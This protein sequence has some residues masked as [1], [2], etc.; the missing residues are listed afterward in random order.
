MAIKEDITWRTIVVYVA[1][2]IF[3]VL[4]LG[5]AFIVMTIEGE[6]WRKKAVANV[7]VIP[8]KIA[9]N[10]GDICAEDG[11]IL[12]TSV[13]YYELR[14]DPVAVKREVF[15]ENIDSLALCLSH[16]FKDGSKAYYKN[17]LTSARNRKPR[18]DRYLL[19]NDRKVNHSELKKI[20]EFP[21]FRLGKNKGGFQSV[22]YNKRI[23]PHVNLASRTI[24]YLNEDEDGTFEGRVGFE[25]AFENQLKGEYGQGMKRMMSGTWMIIADREPEDGQDVVTTL[26]VDYQDIVQTA[27][28]RQL[29]AYEASNGTAI[30]MEVKTGDIKAIANMIRASDGSYREDLNY[31]I[32]D[33]GEPGSVIKAA[34]MIALLEDGHVQPDDTI[35]LGPTGKYKFYDRYLSESDGKGLGKVTVKRI[36]EKSSNGIAKLVFEHY[37][38]K[39]EKFIDRLY[40]MGLDKKLDICLKGEGQPYIKH[41]QDKSW[42]AI[43]LPW[44]S[45]GYE[46]RITPLQ[47]LA[48]YNAIANDGQRMRPRFVKEIRRHG[49]VVKSFSTE[50]VGSKICSRKTLRELK[51]ML[52]GVVE[53]GT[54]KNIYTTKY[55]IAGKTGTARMADGAK[56]YGVRK[57]RASFVGY[58][59]AEE[60]LYSCIVVI[61][62]PSLSKGF[63]ANIVS[64]SA[65]RE[66]SDKV[67]SIAYLRYAKPE[68]EADKSLP[69]S[70]NGLKKDF[71][72]V[73]DELDMDLDGTRDV[74]ETDWVMTASDK[75]ENVMLMPR[76]ITFSTVPNVKGMGLR[77]ALFVL[78]NSGLKV[79]SFG[80]GMVQSQS[81]QPGAR[82]GRGTYI[83]IELR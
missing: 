30:L 11:R 71:L 62:N 54:A 25:G 15:R 47:V 44:M 69:V 12:A 38:G 77:D 13:P 46:L 27:L 10:R 42:N 66:I 32:G 81:I 76:K 39:P 53:E 4:V 72:T 78:E 67:Y 29:E 61:D 19:I 48:F 73:F 74:R 59:P 8:V 79:G 2:V 60:P 5:R 35:D 65:F 55:R 45:I 37:K 16:F 28:S 57:Y 34:T 22:V 51:D 40:G 24:G 1:I 75:S 9:P 43:T 41:P 58:F 17:K 21:I 70:K 20:R 36:M 3:G 80:S 33:A 26:D 49:E 63:Y 56:G 23:Q 50:E 7:P 82:V 6:K 31:A 64:A 18:P 52:E 68:Y 14:F 83:Q